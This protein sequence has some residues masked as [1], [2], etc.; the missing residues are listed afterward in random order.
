[1]KIRW[2][3]HSS[4]TITAED[5]TVIVTDP[6]EP[7][8]FGGGIGY[9][10]VDSEPDIVT[11]S[12]DHA[13]HNYTE[14]F[15]TEFKEIRGNGEAA[16]IKFEG[17]DSFHDANQGADRGKNTIICFTVNGV[18]ICHLGDL[19]HNLD[20]DFLGKIGK[21]DILLA[22]VGGFYTIDAPTATDIVERMRPAIVIPM[23]F[24]TEKCGF[25][26]A[27]VAD[28]THGKKTVREIDAD[29]IELFSD[30]L[31]GETEVIV[32]RHRL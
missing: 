3:G 16:G 1:M 25:P 28:F 18:R 23:H 11:V 29:E 24:K 14:G 4:F 27:E 17:Y 7:G 15:S 20:Q 30:K 5:G 9:V 22:P 10:A 13:D 21:V 26:I 8:A 31:P 12:H 32:L 19:G 6:Y 2:N